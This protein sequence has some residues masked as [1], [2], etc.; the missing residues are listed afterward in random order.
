MLTTKTFSLYD[1]GLQELCPIL[2]QLGLSTWSVCIEAINHNIRGVFD[3]VL[4]L[5]EIIKGSFQKWPVKI[6]LNFI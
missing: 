4:L 1:E 5:L 2:N 3:N 6:T